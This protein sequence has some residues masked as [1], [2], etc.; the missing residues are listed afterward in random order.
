[1]SEIYKYWKFFNN[2]VLHSYSQIFFSKNK[3]FAL[4]ILLASFLNPAIGFWGFAAVIFTNVLAKWMEFDYQTNEDGL[5]GLN[6]LLVVLGLAV[7]FNVNFSFLFVFITINIF[8]LLL[9]VGI[10][11]LMA[12]FNLPFLAFPFIIAMWVTFYV[13]NSYTNLEVNEG[14]VYFL[15]DIFKIGGQLFLNLYETFETLPIPDFI[16]GY[17]KS[18]A[19]IVFQF[20]WIAGIFIAIGL[21]ISSRISFTLS[22][23]GYSTGYLYY[24]IVGENLNNLHYGYIGFNFIL[25]AIAVGAFYF[26]SKRKVHLAVIILTPVLGLMITGLSG[27]LAVFGLPVFALPFMLMTVLVIYTMNYTTNLSTFPKVIYQT[28]SPEKN[29]YNYS[30]YMERFGSNQHFLKIGLPFYGKWK[31]W[32]GHEGKHTHKGDWKNAWDFVIDD[33]KGNTFKNDGHLL[34]DYYCYNTPIVAPA[35]GNVVNIVDGIPDNIPGEINMNQNWG[36]TIV[37]KHSDFLY[38]QISHLKEDSFKVKEGDFVKKGQ[39]LAKLGNSGRSPQP[40]IHFQ[41]QTTPF[42]GSKTLKYPLS[43]FIK[44][45]ENTA[46]FSSFDYPVEGDNLT[47]VKINKTINKAFKMIPGMIFEVNSTQPEFEA[48]EWEIN[49]DAYNLTYIVCAKSK[50]YA[51]FVNDGTMLYFTSFEGDKNSLLYYFYLSAF[52]IFLGDYYTIKVNDV[53]PIHTVFGGYMKFFQDIIAPYYQ[54]CSADYESFLNEVDKDSTNFTI[55]ATLTKKIFNKMKEQLNF[56]IMGNDNSLKK[57]EVK[58]PQSTFD[59]NLKLKL[60]Y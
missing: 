34:E 37:I 25:F 55:T 21:F 13:M 11:N 4:L 10:S 17:F 45:T 8:T 29:L 56:K 46:V 38:S 48:T 35:D 3:S 5:F 12:R 19:A 18:L 30:N 7:F 2:S 40:H 59:I 14:N 36:N 28:Y 15:N 9:S 57:I 6:S 20:N 53:L 26:V 49:T 39:Q 22:L 16:T 60:N 47:D 24:M 27:F 43:Y 32:Q 51:Y 1:M 41:L 42:I 23:I 54:Y 58:T 50:A 44:E 31:V 52:K 33:K